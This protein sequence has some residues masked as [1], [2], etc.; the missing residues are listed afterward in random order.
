MAKPH[1]G[2]RSGALLVALLA[3]AA[4]FSGAE[5]AKEG[6]GAYA[7]VG[8]ML[9][10]EAGLSKDLAGALVDVMKTMQSVDPAEVGTVTTVLRKMEDGI[11]QYSDQVK[12]LNQPELDALA[13]RLKAK[14]EEQ[15]RLVKARDERKAALDAALA[16]YRDAVAEE[17]SESKSMSAEEKEAEAELT[18]KERRVKVE[19][20][21]V[22]EQR[23][24]IG[25]IR[26]A[27]ERMKSQIDAE[28]E[29]EANVNDG[30]AHK[31]TLKVRMGFRGYAPSDFP[32]EQLQLGVQRLVREQLDGVAVGVSVSAASLGQRTPADGKHACVSYGL[33]FMMVPTAGRCIMSDEASCKV[34]AGMAG[35]GKQFYKGLDCRTAMVEHGKKREALAAKNLPGTKPIGK[36]PALVE[37]PKP[38]PTAAAPPA[39]AASKKGGV[40]TGIKSKIGSITSKLP[41]KLKK[42]G[43]RFQSIYENANSN[44]N[45]NN[46]AQGSHRF[47]EVQAEAAAELD[48][49]YFRDP[50]EEA[51]STA[52]F[53]EGLEDS[54]D[55]A[56]AITA[57]LH[58]RTARQAAADANSNN[59]NHDSNREGKAEAAEDRLE[60]LEARG[61]ERQLDLD[62]QQ[63]EESSESRSSSSN[64]LRRRLLSNREEAQFG[65]KGGGGKSPAF[66]FPKFKMPKL[67]F[68]PRPPAPPVAALAVKPKP[69]P[70]GPGGVAGVGVL[71]RPKPVILPVVR[72]PPVPLT[73]KPPMKLALYAEVMV[74]IS[75]DGTNVEDAKAQRAAVIA[76]VQD[77][78]DLL[79]AFKKEVEAA[80]D[81]NPAGAARLKPRGPLAVTRVVVSAGAPDPLDREIEANAEEAE[82]I[83]G[84]ISDQIETEEDACEA[85][86]HTCDLKTSACVAASSPG[87][88]TCECKEH[89]KEAA[90]GDGKCELVDP[91]DPGAPRHDCDKDA[92]CSKTGEPGGYTC[93]CREGFRGDGTD[94]API[95]PCDI[96]TGPFKHRCHADAACLGTGPNQYKCKCRVGFIGNGVQCAA[97]RVDPCIACD[98]ARGEE[99]GADEKTGARRCVCKRGF[100]GRPGSRSPCRAVDP[101]KSSMND[102]DKENGICKAKDPKDPAA[103]VACACRAGFGGDGKACAP[104]DPCKEGSDDCDKVHGKCSFEGPGD[105]KCSCATKGMVLGKDFKSCVRDPCAAGGK[106]SCDPENGVCSTLP[107]G[108]GHQCACKPGYVPAKGSPA[109]SNLCQLDLSNPAAVSAGAKQGMDL[110][111]LMKAIMGGAAGAAGAAGAG[112]GMTI[113]SA[114]TGAL[115]E[116][117]GKMIPGSQKFVPTVAVKVGGAD[118]CAFLLRASW[119]LNVGPLKDTPLDVLGGVCGKPLAM[120]GATL[121]EANSGAFFGALLPEAVSAQLAATGL[122]QRVSLGAL[123]GAS[124]AYDRRLLKATGADLKFQPPASPLNGLATGNGLPALDVGLVIGLTGRL[125]KPR[126]QAAAAAN[127]AC[128]NGVGCKLLALMTGSGSVTGSIHVGKV[129]QGG[130]FGVGANLA[131]DLGSLVFSNGL[132]VDRASLALGLNFGAPLPK[133]PLPDGAAFLEEEAEGGGGAVPPMAAGIMQK[134]KVDMKVAGKFKYVLDDQG[135][136][137]VGEMDAQLGGNL[138]ASTA[139]ANIR[140]TEPWRGVFGALGRRINVDDLTGTLQLGLPSIAEIAMG[141]AVGGEIRASG[142]VCVGK[143]GDC[144]PTKDPKKTING[145]VYVTA[146]IDASKDLIKKKDPVAALDS[147]FAMITVDQVTINNLLN[148]FAGVNFKIPVVGEIGVTGQQ[149][150]CPKLP[151]SGGFTLEQIEATAPCKLAA[152]LAFA[153]QDGSKIGAMAGVRAGIR[154]SG[155]VNTLRTAIKGLLFGKSPKMDFEAEL[156][157]APEEKSLK[158]GL[159]DKVKDKKLPGKVAAVYIDLTLKE[160]ISLFGGLIQ[161]T[162]KENGSD[163]PKV[164]VDVKTSAYKS[165]LTSTKSDDATWAA[166]AAITERSDAREKQRNSRFFKSVGTDVGAGQWSVWLGGYAKFLGVGVGAELEVR[167]DGMHFHAEAKL[168]NLFMAR[169][170]IDAAYGQ[171]QSKQVCVRGMLQNDLMTRLREAVRGGIKK[172]K[173]AAVKGISGWQDKV[174]A[175]KKK[176]ADA[177]RS[178]DGAKKKFDDAANAIKSKRDSLRKAEDKVDNICFIEMMKSRR[179]RRRFGKNG[180]QQQQQQQQQRMHAFKSLRFSKKLGGAF[181]ERLNDMAAERAEFLELEQLSK[182]QRQQQQHNGGEGAGEDDEMQ[183][184]AFLE[185]LREGGTSRHL[186]GRVKKGIRFRGIVRSV[187][188]GL[189]SAARTVGRGVSSAVRTVG[190]GLSTAVRAVGNVAKKVGGTIK[191]A[192][193]A[194]GNA[195]KDAGC[196][197]LKNTAKLGLKAAQGAMWVAEKAV[198]AAKVTVEAA[199]GVLYLAEGVMAAANAGLEGAKYAVKGAMAVADFMAKWLLGGLFDV[200][201]IGFNL[202]FGNMKRN[203]LCVIMDLTILKM[204]K[205]VRMNINLDSFGSIVSSLVNMVLGKGAPKSCTMNCPTTDFKAADSSQAFPWIDEKKAAAALAAKKTAEAAQAAASKAAA[206]NKAASAR[207]SAELKQI[208]SNDYVTECANFETPGDGK[209]YRLPKGFLLPLSGFARVHVT[210]NRDANLAFMTSNDKDHNNMCVWG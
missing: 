126:P 178:L 192:A 204:E 124:T 156:L 52:E 86:T 198:R 193:V 199:K 95:N 208:A 117:L 153:P 114:Q 48:A 182:Q 31:A 136:Q 5:A 15:A 110:G 190:R 25:K 81:L 9:R 194:V 104:L 21:H 90:E 78:E 181:G 119:T 210:G 100:S 191:N 144:F 82:E 174:N 202:Y 73:P 169:L 115:R 120:V 62:A 83:L 111:G 53:F 200:R 166:K 137:V 84:E 75:V 176:V 131:A 162:D 130:G 207:A 170:Q 189:S 60:A 24:Y 85:G 105:F 91:C 186:S 72:P 113:G 77:E 33:G 41:L 133:L 1:R 129:G 172:A 102:C 150:G 196:W 177:R 57:R 10:S 158:E 51:A 23:A 106:N 46:N 96:A 134:V 79:A 187:G 50:Q 167:N 58:A 201:R 11:D 42:S 71:P 203:S 98:D 76:V 103:G 26:N 165:A 122:F 171:S 154:I 7:G 168:W 141:G 146:G 29:D 175:A 65:R 59:N 142:R 34:P 2:R 6:T 70:V 45:N 56:A 67:P 125:L 107:D 55:R 47:A 143:D 188:R 206:A 92:T 128:D 39:P 112:G 38:K 147:A 18:D 157:L 32:R 3:L 54:I 197:A 64:T 22:D 151:S 37:K 89:F 185:L 12:Q 36:P 132:T 99:C 4:L 159:L 152:T 160:K 87:E 14:E 28:A 108:G 44:S 184:A 209:W 109:G 19:V 135:Q 16:K 13:G 17:K 80:M 66:K 179:G 35:A 69:V 140:Q 49:G 205:T 27:L 30:K 101:C 97:A 43:A 155:G 20:Q 94:C 164:L 40:L 118:G 173:D 68:I 93:K 61:E 116:A 180:Q 139:T 121:T 148:T 63:A 149:T 145:Q 88:F 123:V 183:Q 163:G 74:A 127:A 161:L 8:A 195:V 138:A